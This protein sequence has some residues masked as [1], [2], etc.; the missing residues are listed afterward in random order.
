MRARSHWK[1]ITL[2]CRFLRPADCQ[3]AIQQVANLRYGR[4]MREKHQP[5]PVKPGV[6]KI[7]QHEKFFPLSS[8]KGGTCIGIGSPIGEANVLR[9]GD[10][11]RS[12][13]NCAERTHPS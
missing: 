13:G 4:L 1:K 2:T 9:A 3:S 12:W 8:G 5:R 11:S 10:G 6:G 7:A